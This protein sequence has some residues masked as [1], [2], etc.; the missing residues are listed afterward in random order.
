[1]LFS[2]IFLFTFSCK[3]NLEDMALDA[4]TAAL[5]QSLDQEI[6]PLTINPLIWSDLDLQFLDPM[7]DKSITC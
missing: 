4:N 5:V 1:M 6:H 3:D 2:L 7:A